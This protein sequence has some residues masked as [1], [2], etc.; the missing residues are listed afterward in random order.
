LDEIVAASVEK[1]KIN[2][3]APRCFTPLYP[4]KLVLSSPTSNGRSV[5]IVRLQTKDHGVCIPLV[6]F[7]SVDREKV[8]TSGFVTCL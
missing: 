8:V 6:V 2:G 5:G 7:E 1:I 3:C 4:Q